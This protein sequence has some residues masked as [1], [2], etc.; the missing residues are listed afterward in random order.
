[1][2]GTLVGIT[3]PVSWGNPMRY[4]AIVAYAACA[5]DPPTLSCF[6]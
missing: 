2:A 5:G 1:M 3:W 4:G 6:S